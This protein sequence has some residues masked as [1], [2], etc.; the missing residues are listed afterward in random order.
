MSEKIVT[1]LNE[2]EYLIEVELSSARAT[3]ILSTDMDEGERKKVKRSV[4]VFA[5]KYKV[6]VYMQI[7]YWDQERSSIQI[8]RGKK[9]FFLLLLPNEMTEEDMEG[10]CEIIGE[11]YEP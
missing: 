7:R 5:N 8:L 3:I 4:V 9:D 6:P 10:L 1:F 11:I 2:K